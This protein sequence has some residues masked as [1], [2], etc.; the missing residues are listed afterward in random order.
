MKCDLGVLGDFHRSA[1]V[2]LAPYLYDSF[3]NKSRIDYGT[4]HETNFFAFLFCLARLGLVGERDRVAL[5]ANLRT[6]HV[7][8]SRGS[9]QLVAGREF[10]RVSVLLGRS[11]VIDMLFAGAVA[12]FAGDSEL[13]NECIGF[14]L[15]QML[16][17]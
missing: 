5:T 11:V 7:S 13:A 4:G 2:E 14:R 12:S 16:V 17:R 10:H 15:I 6:P 1:S 9:N 8:Q 3:G